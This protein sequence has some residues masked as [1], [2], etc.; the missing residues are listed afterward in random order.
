MLPPRCARRP[1]VTKSRSKGGRRKEGRRG[2][3]RGEKRSGTHLQT[4]SRPRAS[5]PSSLWLC[6]RHRGGQQAQSGSIVTLRGNR[7][8]TEGICWF[9]DNNRFHCVRRGDDRE[10]SRQRGALC[11]ACDSELSES[12]VLVLRGSI[13][14]GEG[15]NTGVIVQRRFPRQVERSTPLRDALAVSKGHLAQGGVFDKADLSKGADHEA[16][17]KPVAEELKALADAQQI[18][19]HSETGCKEGHGLSSLSSLHRA[20]LLATKL[21]VAFPGRVTARATLVQA[22]GGAL[23]SEAFRRRTS[24]LCIPLRRTLDQCFHGFLWDLIQILEKLVAATF[25]TAFLHPGPAHQGR[26]MS[27]LASGSWE[28]LC[29]GKSWL[30]SCAP[31]LLF[32]YTRRRLLLD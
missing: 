4:S 32:L 26:S 31:E 8:W 3:R 24:A 7:Q 14:R 6:H 10:A 9:T 12:L 22:I 29:A 25:A 30:L 20:I 18:F 2:E 21:A 1:L 16:S 27:A 5:I 15:F 17:V 19:L 13:R 11:D 23:L 28:G